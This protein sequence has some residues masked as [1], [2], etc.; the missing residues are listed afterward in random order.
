[1]NTCEQCGEQ[2]PEEK[3]FCPNCGNSMTPERQRTPMFSEEMGETMLGFSLPV[4]NPPPPKP[5]PVVPARPTQAPPAPA[6]VPR[7]TDVM[8]HVLP[9]QMPQ[10]KPNDAGLRKLYLILGA[11]AVLFA[12]SILFVVVLYMMGKL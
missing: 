2:V 1:M 6:S 12:L 10:G 3:A 7:P 8:S 9:K 4:K 11:A 5:K